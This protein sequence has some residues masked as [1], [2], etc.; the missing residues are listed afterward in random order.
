MRNSP[1]GQ[2]ALNT[3]DEMIQGATVGIHDWESQPHFKIGMHSIAQSDDGTDH[4]E[5][6]VCRKILFISEQCI[7]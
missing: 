5:V 4:F 2:E 1:W 3:K 6:K 7:G